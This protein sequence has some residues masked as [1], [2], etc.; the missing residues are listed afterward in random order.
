[1]AEFEEGRWRERE[2]GERGDGT[3][4]EADKVAEITEVAPLIKLAVQIIL[5]GGNPVIK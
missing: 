1:M 4:D 2:S 5:R 3:T